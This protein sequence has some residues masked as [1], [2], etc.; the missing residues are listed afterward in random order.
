MSVPR[1]RLEGLLVLGRRHV[2]RAVDG[3]LPRGSLPAAGCRHGVGE[4]GVVHLLDGGSTVLLSGGRLVDDDVPPAPEQFEAGGSDRNDGD[5]T[6]RP[7]AL[8]VGL[9]RESGFR[10]QR[11]EKSKTRHERR[12]FRDLFR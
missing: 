8:G 7:V 5:P 12:S 11:F 10:P 4:A 1:T 3:I 2:D 6:Q 9:E